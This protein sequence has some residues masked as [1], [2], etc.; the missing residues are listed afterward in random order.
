MLQTINGK[1][2]YVVEFDTM[3]TLPITGLTEEEQAYNLILQVLCGGH[4]PHHVLTH[5]SKYADALNQAFEMGI[6]T[7]PG[8]YAIHIHHE[9][10]SFDISRVVEPV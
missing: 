7:E 1:T 8:K 5:T 10:G 6:I 2:V 4:A 9:E 3:P